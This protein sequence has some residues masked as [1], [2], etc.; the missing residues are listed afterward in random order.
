MDPGLRQQVYW[1]EAHSP[2]SLPGS[3]R[4]ACC[5]YQELKSPKPRLGLFLAV[6]VAVLVDGSSSAARFLRHEK[7]YSSCHKRARSLCLRVP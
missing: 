5:C 1:L 2:A 7:T 4:P 6:E 3:L